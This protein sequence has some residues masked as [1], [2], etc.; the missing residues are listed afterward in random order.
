[1]YRN[2]TRTLAISHQPSAISVHLSKWP[3]PKPDYADAQLVADMALAQR[4][5]G[6]GRAA[7]ESANLKL[8]QPLAEAIVGLPNARE[9]EALLRLADEVVKEELNVKALRTVAAGSDLV[10]V[11]IHPLPKQLGQKHGRRFPA[12]RQALLALDPLAVAA[13]VEA[14]RAVTVTVD[15]E[16]IEVL[17]D[18]VQVRKSPKKGLAV[19]EETGYLVAVTTGLT[20]EL[21]W[22]GWAR[23]ISRNIQELR[24]KSG[25]EISDR[26]HTTVQ[27]GP[28]LAP[29]WQHHAAAIAADTLSLTFAQAAPVEGAFTASVSLDGEDVVIG[30]R[31]A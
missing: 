7:R 30:V 9:A 23:E 26:I 6:L 15:D 28:K 18:E 2:L 10:D 27:A 3:S 25:F 4:V 29:V 11:A 24:K 21:R 16:T 13:Q 1:M 31:K 5:V 22:E 19:A 14:G 12:I 17:S 20:D 8:R